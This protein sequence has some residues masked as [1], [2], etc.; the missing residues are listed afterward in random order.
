MQRAGKLEGGHNDF[1]APHHQSFVCPNDHQFQTS[2]RIEASQ[3][4]AKIA[5]LFR[6][7]I[8][9]SNDIW[10]RQQ[11]QQPEAECI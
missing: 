3:L 1:E 11:H 9:Y 8:E 5:F 2:H 10:Q 7:Y 6:V 4:A